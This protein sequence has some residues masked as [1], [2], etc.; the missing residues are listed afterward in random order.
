MDPQTECI[1]YRDKNNKI[2]TC[3][4]EINSIFKDLKMPPITSS[5]LPTLTVPAGLFHM[6]RSFQDNFI[7][8]EKI[9]NISDDLYEKLLKEFLYLPQKNKSRK[10][11]RKRKKSQSRKRS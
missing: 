8:D 11:K 3:G 1:F 5:G 6:Q 9:N 4:Y 7:E 10:R 2:L